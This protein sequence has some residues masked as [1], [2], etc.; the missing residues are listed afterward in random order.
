MN[1]IK[2][3]DVVVLKSGSPKMTVQ[4]IR[5]GLAI[6]VWF[7]GTEALF[8]EFRPEALLLFRG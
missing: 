8:G 7:S 5:D 1:E 4:A 3:G 6:C 2:A